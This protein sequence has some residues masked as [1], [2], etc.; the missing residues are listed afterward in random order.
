MQL[1][2]IQ[3]AEEFDKIEQDWDALLVNV[4]EKQ[5]F[6]EYRWAKTF[7]SYYAQGLLSKLCIVAGYDNKKLILLF[8]FIF[9]QGDLKFITYETSDYNMI[10]VDKTYNRYVII[11]KAVKFLVA[12]IP[13]KKICLT[14]FRQSSELY[15]MLLSLRKNDYIAIL[16]ESIVSPYL[17]M[18]QD[19]DKK[20]QNKQ[21]NDIRRREKRLRENHKLEYVTE[22]GIGRHELEFISIHR[23]SKYG[24]NP[25]SDKNVIDFYLELGKQLPENILINKAYIDEKLASLHFGFCDDNKIYYYV[26]IYDKKY[27]KDGIGMCLLLHVLEE[28]KDKE[29]FDFLKGDE[30]YKFYWCDDAVMNYHLLAYPKGKDSFFPRLILKIKDWKFVRRAMGR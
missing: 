2:L 9:E 7:L 28:N 23:E 12:N 24:K 19:C 14:N 4:S 26:P 15:N 21:I 29:I 25:F 18:S 1:K 20:F 22:R 10:Y 8:P 13:I 16:Q 30:N 3:T 11:D 27:G 5:I 6:Y 17:I